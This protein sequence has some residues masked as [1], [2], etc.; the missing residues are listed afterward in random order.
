MVSVRPS[1]IA[2]AAAAVIATGCDPNVNDEARN[3]DGCGPNSS[4][5]DEHEHCHCDDG[6]EIQGTACLPV[7]GDDEDEIDDI[8]AID[9]DG[10]ITTGQSLTDESGEAVFVLQAVAGDVL[11]RIEGYVG[12]G[13]PD[14]PATVEL[15]GDELNYAT[16]AVCVIVQTGCSAHDDHFHCDRTLMPTGGAV[17]FTALDPLSTLAGHLHALRLQP[18]QIAADYQTTPVE[19]PFGLV[20]HWEFQTALSRR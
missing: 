8:N 6:F 13:A 15:A 18:V 1:L 4:F 3:D 11:L 20:D 19:G 9:L 7:D 5:S 17:E 2:L 10:A 16:C 12:F 14:G